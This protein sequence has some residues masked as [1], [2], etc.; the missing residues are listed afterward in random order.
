MSFHPAEFEIV[1]EDH[2]RGYHSFVG[3]Q[4]KN[5]GEPRFVL[6]PGFDD[7]PTED[8]EEVSRYFFG[9]FQALRQFRDFYEDKKPFSESDFEG[10]DGMVVEVDR[11]EPA[12][13]YTKIGVLEKVLSRFDELRIY[14]ILYRNRRTD[15]IDYSQ[16]HRYLDRAIYQDDV[17][18]VEE[19][20]LPKPA[21]E[22]SVT[23]LV[24]MFCFIYAEIAPRI[25][26][27]LSQ[28][29][30][31]E[32]ARFQAEHLSPNSGLFGEIDVHRRTIDNL[33]F[34]LDRIDREVAHKGAD[35]WYFFEAVETF[36]YGRLAGEGDGIS[37]GITQFA[38]VWEDMCMTWMRAK[39]WDQVRYAD[40]ERFSNTRLKGHDLY[41]GDDFD[42][43]FGVA[44]SG[45]KRY[46]R[47]DIVTK[48]EQTPQKL[49]EVL[50][51]EYGKV[52][53][54]VRKKN[55][56]ARDVLDWLR[57]NPRLSVTEDSKGQTW[58][59]TFFGTSKNAVIE[60]IKRFGSE[61]EVWRVIDI[62]CVPTY[63][64]G[65]GGMIH[66]TRMDERKQITY[67][68]AL[69]L[70]GRNDTRSQF[71]LPSYFQEDVEGIGRNVPESRLNQKLV[72]GGMQVRRVDFDQT[73]ETYL[74][75]ET[76]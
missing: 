30:R 21:I 43:P 64:F 58:A 26:K 55:E 23:T 11:S 15:D 56:Q 41:C 31:S 10:E 3:V 46:M 60:Q 18:Y 62:K 37:W 7:F 13:L 51:K 27:D 53:V 50:D 63:L 59:Y 54:R 6:P 71:F 35:Y 65:K 32:A 47:P 49:L 34:V 29:V 67:E 68:H 69:Q 1:H 4:R 42:P 8:E 36:L 12:M 39:R 14:N 73:L 48:E 25:G 44:I 5:G 38:P 33:Q 28:K 16:I 52:K 19:M 2:D 75:E 40:S 61:G 66:K 45:E 72:D 22:L 70:S 9:L 74:G 57:H 20:R 24:R 76:R 17:P